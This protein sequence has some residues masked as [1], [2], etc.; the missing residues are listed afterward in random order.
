MS[1]ALPTYPELPAA[2]PGVSQLTAD[3]CGAW[4]Y[5]QP[6]RDRFART[7]LST[8]TVLN[9]PG[10]V[11]MQGLA[12]DP[13]MSI[14][15][16]REVTVPSDWVGQ[17]IR[18]RFEA[19]YSA[20]EIWIDGHPVAQHVGGFTPIDIDITPMARPG[21][22]LRLTLYV[23][24]SSVADLI[25]FGTRYADHPLIGIPRKAFLYCLPPA[26]IAG[27][28]ITTEFPDGDYSQAVL[29]LDVDTSQ[30]SD[31]RVKLIDPDNRGQALGTVSL[32]ANGVLKFP[33]SQPRLWDT[34]TPALYT[35]RLDYGGA[36]YARK[37]GFR[38]FSVKDRRPHLNGRPILLRGV[39]H[40]QTHP[41]T[42]RA[43][44][45]RWAETDV[46][47]FRDA[48]VNF[49]RTSHYP[50]TIEL[51]EA[52]DAAGMLLEIEA[53]VCFA[54]GQF[55]HMPEWGQLSQQEQDALSDYIEAASLEMV[56][57]YRSHPSVVIWSVANESHWAQPFARSSQAIRAADPSR[58]QTYNWWRLEDAC[59][60]Y[61]EI[62]NHHYPDAGTV[63]EFAEE[64][65]PVQFDEFAH[66][67]CYSDRE[68]ATDPGLRH[69]WGG[70]LARQ[71]QE[72]VDLPNGA[73]GSIW[74]AIDDWFAVPERDGGI[75]WRGY[76]EWGPIDGWR[77]PKPEY[78]Q[79][80]RVFD[81]LQVT[82]QATE[83]GKAI[84]VAIHNRFDF[85]DLSDVEFTWQLGTQTGRQRVDG[86][87]GAR[88]SFR[89]PAPDGEERLALMA[90]V[91]RLGYER[92]FP[93]AN[94]RPGTGEE[95]A[96]TRA[97][98][99]DGPVLKSD[100][101]KVAPSAGGFALSCDK[102]FGVEVSLALIPQ[103]FTR[104]QGV[105]GTDDLLPLDSTVG[106]WALDRISAREGR[107]VVSG[108]YDR[109]KGRFE[110]VERTDGSLSLSYDFELLQ[111]FEPFQFGIALVVDK[112]FDVLDWR[113]SRPCD[114]DPTNP[115]RANGR[116][117]AWRDRE[118]GPDQQRAIRPSWPWAEDQAVFGTHDFCST[119][120]NVQLASLTADS[121][122]GLTVSNPDGM[123][124]RAESRPDAT[125]LYALAYAS[126]GSEFFHRSFVE[127]RNLQAGERISGEFVLR[128]TRRQEMT[129]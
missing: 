85:A 105:K 73:G 125:H 97:F 16:E 10:E 22:T 51:V 42:G 76:G 39:N 110:L 58:P 69:H 27:L 72:I 53:P 38:E 37:V 75:Q 70:F 50:P 102:G 52:C 48:N 104:R 19:V 6:I 60:D 29:R 61:V 126:Q 46:R 109:A 67:Y 47:L 95:T 100:D 28:G 74:A 2:L 123:H 89:L 12:Y 1:V 40:H 35:L 88:A 127:N 20:C 81:P 25:A 13:S 3:L 43:D 79:M 41:T 31:L 94:D 9:V 36:S 26:H 128:A 83:D 33:V 8:D 4:A 56:A 14:A 120:R 71:W 107:G 30:A 119:K 111:A 23:D 62:A 63:G 113:S 21:E 78:D 32:P 116:A 122:T 108:S 49:I 17:M 106:D 57:F 96:P 86:A 99:A 92:V 55:G 98:V 44:T 5:Q 87:P 121:G 68:L 7:P 93:Y 117:K 101:W 112:A 15:L 129:V 90:R 77:R 103:H 18:A 11:V 91:P 124:V 65:R 114:L 64:P 82:M 115:A 54:F 24:N 34:E 80:K 66:L 84:R 45:A 59:R 118:Q